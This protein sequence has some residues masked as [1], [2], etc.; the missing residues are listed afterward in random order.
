MDEKLV[1]SCAQNAVELS[2]LALQDLSNRRMAEIILAGGRWVKQW[3]AQTNKQRDV[4][5]QHQ[6]VLDQCNMVSS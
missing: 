6:W 2:V 1:R 4:P 5:T 3:H